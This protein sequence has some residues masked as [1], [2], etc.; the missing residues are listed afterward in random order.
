VSD[1]ISGGMITAVFLIMSAFTAIFLIDV[2]TDHSVLAGQLSQRQADR[3]N[4]AIAFQSDKSYMDLGCNTLLAVADNTGRIAITDFARMDVLADYRDTSD[5][6]VTIHPAYNTDWTVGGI[7]PDI[8]DPN[9]WNPEEEATFTIPISPLMGFD[10]S[11]TVVLVTPQGVSDSGYFSCPSNHYF[12]AETTTSITGS[13]YYQLKGIPSDGPATTLST[14]FTSEQ[15]GRVRPSPNDGKF[16]VPLTNTSQIRA[17]TWDVTYRL[18]RDKADFGFVWSTNADDLTLPF[19]DLWWD[20]DLSAYVPVG[21]TGAIVEVVNTGVGLA[22][23]VV[24]GKEDPRNYMFNPS[25]GPIL[26]EPETHQWQIVKVDGNRLIQGYITSTDIQFKLLGYTIGPDPSFFSAPPDITTGSTGSWATAN[27]SSNVDADADGAILLVVGDAK[28]YGIREV[29]SSFSNVDLKLPAKGHT[30][31]LVGLNSSKE[32]E[33]YIET[34]VNIYLMGQTKGSVVYYTDDI[35]ATNPATGSWAT[36][37]AD[38]FSVPAE[39]NGLILTAEVATA[40]DLG[41]RHGDS[42]DDWNKRILDDTHVQGAAGINSDNQWQEYLGE[43]GSGVFIAAYTRLVRMDVH[44]DIDVLVRQAD[45]A[46]R[47]TLDTDVA[48]SSNVT[49]TDWQTFTATFPFA[50]YTVVDN[51]DYLEI[52]LFANATANLSGEDVTVDFRIDD[53]TLPLADQARVLP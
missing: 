7:N 32:F 44:A 34:G 50:E 28:K 20:I 47:A 12:H 27:L 45:G 37:D 53:P 38:T 46:I 8:R 10:T 4:T 29:G 24:R 25:F 19:T 11:G 21:A 33:A 18:R 22:G 16:I 3:A 23:G 30:M 36:L 17:T 26:L 13:A 14:V 40:G 49:G 1:S 6:K 48:D 9:L 2:W 39:A 43:A 41:L 31:Y 35:A 15:A 52:D 51:T 42:T 5:D